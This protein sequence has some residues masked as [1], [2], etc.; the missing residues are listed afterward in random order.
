MTTT[1]VEYRARAEEF[2]AMAQREPNPDCR[3]EYDRLAQ[4]YVRLASLA[5][6]NSRTDVVYET[7][8]VAAG[9]DGNGK[10]S[11]SAG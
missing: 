3:E 4:C 8:S 1:A 6:R 5:E 7:P 2:Q 9:H 11:G 10:P